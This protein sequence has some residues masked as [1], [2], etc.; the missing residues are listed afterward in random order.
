MEERKERK[1]G[2][3]EEGQKNKVHVALHSGLLVMPLQGPPA[4]R[5][6]MGPPP[7]SSLPRSPKVLWLLPLFR[8]PLLW[9]TQAEPALLLTL[10]CL[11]PSAWPVS[12]T[13]S[14]HAC[15]SGSHQ[16]HALER[17]PILALYFFIFPCFH[18]GASWGWWRNRP[19]ASSVHLPGPVLSSSQSTLLPW[20]QFP[21]LTADQ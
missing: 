4:P 16:L 14:R 1:E 17:L 19:H 7:S 13:G 12:T 11:A 10:L 15:P 6:T 21:N 9:K 3:K 2:G 5:K 20:A 8:A 18:L